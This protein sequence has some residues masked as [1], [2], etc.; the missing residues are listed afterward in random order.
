[1]LT[2]LSKKGAAI[3]IASLADQHPLSIQTSCA[4]EKYLSLAD[5]NNN[6][7]TTYILTSAFLIAGISASAQT[8]T[9]VPMLLP[10]PLLAP[11]EARLVSYDVTTNQVVAIIPGPG[12]SSTQQRFELH[13]NVAPMVR[14]DVTR[15]NA[16]FTY[17]YQV[18]NASTAKSAIAGWA[19]EVADDGLAGPAAVSNSIGAPN[20]WHSASPAPPSVAIPGSIRPTAHLSWNLNDVSRADKASGTTFTLQSKLLPGI[21]WSFARGIIKNEPDPAVTSALPPATA[22]SLRAFLTPAVD[23]VPVITI[24]PKFAAEDPKELIAGEFFQALVLL[25]GPSGESRFVLSAKDALVTY[26]AS[27]ESA[28]YVLKLDFLTQASTPFEVEL[29]NAMRISLSK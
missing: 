25:T 17:T 12:G 28:S 14:V 23:G 1:M 22:A 26:M 9:T 19:V 8:K 3:S 7:K 13:N 11:G 2:E 4:R 15:T 5:N 24:G 21:V 6:M 27:P 16:E 10:G 29:A 18:S 20:G